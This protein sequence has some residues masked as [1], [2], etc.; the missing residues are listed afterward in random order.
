[1]FPLVA[2]SSRLLQL[3]AELPPMIIV[4]IGYKVDTPLETLA[5]R[6]RDLTP[7]LDESFVAEEAAGPIAPT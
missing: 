7:T 1:M 6:T 3:G 4:G 5:L 2:I